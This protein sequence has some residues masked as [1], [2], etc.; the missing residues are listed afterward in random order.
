M[1]VV[2]W[3][4]GEIPFL[5]NTNK[6]MMEVVYIFSFISEIFQ[7]TTLQVLLLKSPLE[8]WFNL[9]SQELP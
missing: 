2:L 6:L 9:L 8:D 4:E 7:G 5:I 3:Y 1:W